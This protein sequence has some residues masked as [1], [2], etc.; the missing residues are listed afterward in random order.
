V[1]AAMRVTTREIERGTA[2]LLLTLP[3]SRPEVYVSSSAVWVFAA[4]LM[5]LAPILG[6]GIASQCIP[7]AQEIVFSRFCLPAVNFFGLNCAVGGICTLLGAVF[8]RQGLVIGLFIAIGLGS[9]AIIF[10]EPFLSFVKYIRF[11]SLLN[12]FRPV[13]IVRTGEFPFGPTCLLLALGVAC[14]LVGLILFCRKDIHTA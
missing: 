13:D 12:Y 1:A 3:V 10:L 2:D 11:L 4:G 9:I 5:S 14:W 8:H 7:S 6:V